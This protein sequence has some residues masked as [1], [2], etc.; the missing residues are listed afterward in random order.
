M[1][2]YEITKYIGRPMMT[3]FLVIRLPQSSVRRGAQILEH[4]QAAL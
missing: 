3:A 2:L 4:Y 1:V